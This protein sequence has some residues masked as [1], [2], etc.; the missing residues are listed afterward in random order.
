MCR[1]GE[2][3]ANWRLVREWFVSIFTTPSS[4]KR[5]F[6][7]YLPSLSLSISADT[8]LPVPPFKCRFTTLHCQLLCVFACLQRLSKSL[9]IALTGLSQPNLGTS[10]NWRLY[11][12]RITASRVPY[13]RNWVDSPTFVSTKKRQIRIHM[14]FFCCVLSNAFDVH[15]YKVVSYTSTTSDHSLASYHSLFLPLAQMHTHTQTHIF[16]A[17]RRNACVGHQPTDGCHTDRT[18]CHDQ[19]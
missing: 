17:H 3:K 13:P 9:A 2:W 14:M 7:R 8:I 15:L 16:T 11:L 6:V 10:S 4:V 18:M 1:K 12:S 19:V 5:H